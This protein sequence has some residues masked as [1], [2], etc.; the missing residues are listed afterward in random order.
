[1]LDKGLPGLVAVLAVT[2]LAFWLLSSRSMALLEPRVPGMDKAGPGA[3]APETDLRGK[4]TQGDAAPA[5][6]LKGLWPW[7]RGPGR[8]NLVTDATPLAKTFPPGGPKLLWSVDLGYGYAAAAVRAGRV[9]VLDYDQVKKAD[10]LRCLSL[11]DGKELWRR[12]YS[13]EIKFN[14]GM[15]RTIPAVTEKYVVTLGPKAH[16]L[17][18][19]AVS[20]EFGW[21]MDLVRE[22][23]AVVPDWYAGQCPLVDGERVILAVGGPDVLLMAV[24][25]ATGK[26]VWRTPNKPNWLMTHASILP[27]TFKGRRMLVYTGSNPQLGTGG[28]V[29]VAPEDGKVLWESA[30]F[31]QKIIAPT[32]L[33]IGEDLVL[34]TAGYNAGS[35]ILRLK[36]EGDRI[37]TE[38]VKRT[39]GQEFSSDQQTPV[40]YQ[41]HIYGVLPSGQL[42][43]ATPAGE[44]LWTSGAGARFGLGPYL[45][46]DGVL[47]LLNDDGVLTLAEASPDGY[48]PLGQWKILDGHDCWGPMALVGGRLLARD[49]SRM[50]CLDV[51]AQGVPTG[52]PEA[53]QP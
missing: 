38:A 3:V 10:A 50:V 14:H 6:N 20:G 17:C 1:V 44:R 16:V 42:A 25:L 12:S 9:Y 32:P 53:K 43:C 26:P 30:A 15:S 27:M 11:A 18:V 21:G 49:L 51:S 34:F 19:D 23:N 47:Y 45:I 46:A 52:G 48:R 31:C 8:D 40:F 37:V 5:A 41:G 33:Q 39:K 7:F 36:Q 22:Y 29:G 2:L 4:F 35:V 13:V 24:D 28:I